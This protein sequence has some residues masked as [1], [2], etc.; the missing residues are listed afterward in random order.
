MASTDKL[1]VV[2][3]CSGRIGTRVTKRFSDQG[4]TVVGFDLDPPKSEAGE[5]DFVKVDLTSDSSVEQGFEHIR[6]KYGTRITAVIHLAA[7]YSFSGEKP[8][9]YDKITVQGTG[10]MINEAKKFQTEQFLFS[11]T[12]LVYK[13]CKPGQRITED[14]PL[15]P[16][17]DYPKS[18]VKT[19]NL[20]HKERGPIPTVV[21][22]IA[23]CYDDECHSIPISTEMQRIFEHQFTGHVYPGNLTHG[24]AY[25][26][27]DDLTEAIWLSVQKRA[28]LPP[29]TVLLIGEDKTLSYDQMQREISKLITGQEMHTFVVPK[30]FAKIGA[31]V[32]NQF[33]SLFQG[34]FIEPWMIDLADDHYEL[35]I[36]KARQLLGWEPQYFVA[37]VLP[38]MVDFLKK[39]PI[40]FYKANGLTAPDWVK[41]KYGKEPAHV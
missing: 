26:H 9:L 28:E 40:A 34:N 8:E 33:P 7:Y 14:S 22:R 12:M 31:W 6:Q 18:K 19:E 35:D 11:S 17:W 41:K 32:E 37:D 27:L 30:W 15:L 16:K 4:F 39:D 29:E 36:T 3:G 25:L 1:I 38:K 23:G 10:R 21:M 24:A 13:P 2:T 20:M 5:V